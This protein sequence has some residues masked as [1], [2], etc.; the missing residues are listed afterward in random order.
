MAK[1]LCGRSD[2]IYYT[3]SSGKCLLTQVAIGKDFK[4]QNY[5]CSYDPDKVDSY[6]KSRKIFEREQ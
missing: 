6:E 3:D 4:C 1:I 5:T 2:C